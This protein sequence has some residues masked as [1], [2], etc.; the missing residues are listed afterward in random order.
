MKNKLLSFLCQ[1]LIIS[2]AIIS[3]LVVVI[4][5]YDRICNK[6]VN[7]ILIT[8]FGNS[9]SNR[10]QQELNESITKIVE[11]QYERT[12]NKLEFS[13]TLFSSALSIFT[14]I[15]GLFYFSRIRETEK[16][17][18]EIQKTPDIFFKKFY[19]EQFK[20]NIST[21]FSENNIKR[22]NAIQSLV[23]NNEIN[24]EDYDVIKTA[25]LKEFDY[26]RNTFFWNNISII[27][28]TLIKIDNSRTIQLLRNLLVDK[29]Y[30]FSKKATLISYIIFDET[31][32]TKEFIKN[33]LLNDQQ[34]S[35]QLVGPMLTTGVMNEYLDYIIAECSGIVLQTV[36][37]SMMSN[38]WHINTNDIA[39]K[40]I[41]RT[42]DIEPNILRSLIN[43]ESITNKDKASII[44]TSYLKNETEKEEVLDYY[45][46]TI[47]NDDKLKIEFFEIAKKLD[48][49]N[50]LKV[51]FVKNKYIYEFFKHIATITGLNLS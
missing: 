7:Q 31:D 9:D 30:D 49:E 27:I 38:Y 14:I 24:I 6:S 37:G 51:Y 10:I 23:F 47:Q 41:Q 16:V 3:V 42:K 44:L 1:V 15:F 13:I 17:I 26:K 34:I 12:I 35:Q 28:N 46:N 4:Y 48:I 8:L 45:L 33:I 32:E 11:E 5:S 18:E 2:F 21:L 25:F 40:F 36:L 22:Y 50:K 19:K 20:N 29:K 39:K 43:I